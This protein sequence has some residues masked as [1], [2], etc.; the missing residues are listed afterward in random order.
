MTVVGFVITSD[1]N[2]DLLG[3]VT[4]VEKLKGAF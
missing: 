4:H 3:I 2:W 1:S